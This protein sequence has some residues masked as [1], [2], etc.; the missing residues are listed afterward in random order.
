[1]R[2]RVRDALASLFVLGG[3]ALVV[4][5]YALISG[6][7][8][9]ASEDCYRVR[10]S[11]V[12][13][14]RVGDPVEVL[15][16]VAGRVRVVELERCSVMVEIGLRRTSASGGG[17]L[18]TNSRFAIRSVSYLGN[19]RFV[20]VTPGTGMPAEAGHVFVGVNEA[21]SLEGT[22]ARLDT[23]LVQLDVARVTA[24]LRSATDSLLRVVKGT[25]PAVNSVMAGVVD[26]MARIADGVDSLHAALTTPSTVRRL[27]TSEEFYQELMTTTTELKALVTDMREHPER[28]FRLR[29]R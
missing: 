26:E 2:R 7:I 13:G 1:M 20:M 16:V 18:P 11:E 27:L 3:I 17:R 21:L 5:V 12:S 14:L 8:G 24:E 9:S 23:L 4:F 22:L 25:L 6:R 15:G 29:L 19:D 10:F 28:Y